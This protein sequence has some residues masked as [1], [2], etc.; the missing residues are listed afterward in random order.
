MKKARYNIAFWGV[1]TLLLLTGCAAGTSTN[2]KVAEAPTHASVGSKALVMDMEG[3]K[4]QLS[5]NTS[6]SSVNRLSPPQLSDDQ[7][8]TYWIERLD[9]NGIMRRTTSSTV[10]HSGDR[11]RLKVRAKLPGYLYVFSKGSAG[12]NGLLYP[13]ENSQG[14]Y[15]EPANIYTI[16]YHGYI[17][18]DDI[19]GEEQMLLVV[20][21]QSINSITPA[22]GNA[23]SNY[24]T[25]AYSACD[26]Q[27]G[28]KSL[29]LEDT[30]NDVV[31][32]KC[33]S[34]IGSKGLRIEEDTGS[35]PMERVSARG[36]LWTQGLYIKR[37]IVLQHR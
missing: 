17:R 28:S 20:S 33:G 34:A 27:I 9:N 10:F 22:G 18:F 24:K 30:E 16:P 15:I 23:G 8:I 21:P 1:L 5:S 14:P 2:D 31:S 13:Q 32:T 12:D 26:N 36:D 3:A 11:I 7:D 6:R 4:V 19:P 29:A 37:T 25:A 35:S